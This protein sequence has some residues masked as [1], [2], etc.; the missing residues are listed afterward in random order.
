MV[1]RVGLTGHTGL[2][3]LTV[4]VTVGEHGPSNRCAALS[5]FASSRKPPS[6]AP[7]VACTNTPISSS[8][9][10]R[11][12][13]WVRQSYDNLEVAVGDTITFTYE[14]AHNVYLHPSGDCTTNDA[15]QVGDN[16]AG[17]A[18]YTFNHPGSFTFACE[19]RVRSQNHTSS[20]PCARSGADCPSVRRNA[21][22]P[23]LHKALPRAAGRRPLRWRRPDNHSHC[24]RPCST[25]GRRRR[26]RGRPGRRG[27]RRRR[28]DWR[29][30]Y[31]VQ[32]FG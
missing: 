16:D 27:R 26:R 28:W 2:R 30:T 23:T 25:M 1:C 29:C 8:V 17:T 32:Q 11:R 6:A 3:R 24:C 15:V 13:D 20:A 14:S 7:A 18:T 5:A 19:V 4:T 10:C 12:V 31:I 9:L 22:P 21:E